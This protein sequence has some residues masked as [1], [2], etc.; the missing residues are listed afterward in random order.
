[1]T[2]ATGHI[3]AAA[4]PAL[5][6]AARPAGTP[7]WQRLSTVCLVA[8]FAVGALGLIGGIADLPILRSVIPGETAI[9]ANAALGCC[10]LALSLACL[11]PL[12]ASTRRR[13]GGY[14]CAGIATGIGLLT[15]WECIFD[16]DL[17]I[18]QAVVAEGL[19]AAYTATPGRMGPYSAITL[20]LKG[21]SLLIL[22]WQSRDGRRPSQLLSLATLFLPIQTLVG[23]T[24]G[25]RTLFGVGHV[26]VTQIAF[27]V[28][29]AWILLSI[30]TLMARPN[31]GMMQV[32]TSQSLAGQTVRLHVLPLMLT[33]WLT[34]LIMSM[35]TRS[36]LYAAEFASSVFI[37]VT[38]SVYASLLWWS[39]G[40]Q[41]ALELTCTRYIA[42]LEQQNQHRQQLVATLSHD[43]RTPLAAALLALEGLARQ[44]WAPGCGAKLGPRIQRSLRYIDDM[45]GNLLDASTQEAGQPLSSNP[46]PCDLAALV[47]EVDED[48]Q[49]LHHGRLMVS[50]PPTLA[51]HWTR[52]QLR[53]LLE[54]L[55]GNAVK[56]GEKSCTISLQVH[57]QA[58][59]AVVRVHNH[60]AALSPAEQRSIF[61]PYARTRAARGERR[62]GWGLGLTAVQSIVDLHGGQTQVHSDPKAGTTFT[63]ILPQQL[64]VRRAQR[65]A[66]VGRHI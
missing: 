40:K 29:V 45:I 55:I 20:V 35:G 1:M 16:V 50:A 36:D 27:H 17:G 7:G 21:L 26:L 22:D 53:R 31:S 33:P 23:Y 39:A 43:M 18:D 10:L 11:R 52:H 56:H 60:G 49:H 2:L 61:A 6:D 66:E 47:R 41:Y 3:A 14:I 25:L 19:D 4:A 48:L 32:A 37:T 28:A 12:D 30:A 42:R 5:V 54:N 8:A 51:G 59:Q 15:L 58:G 46:Q 44:Q 63:V 57:E 13:L 24:F 34:G 38:M 65:R 62:Q 9:K 64:R